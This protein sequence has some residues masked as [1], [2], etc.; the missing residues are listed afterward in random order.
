MRVTRRY[1]I[2]ALTPTM[3]VL[4]VVLVFPTLYVVQLAFQKK[5][6]TSLAPAQWVGLDNFTALLSD[7]RFWSALWHSALFSG[8]SL[9][10][11]IPIGCLLGA[12]MARKLPG[13]AF[14]RT[15]MILPMVVTP[16]VIG[17]LF[18]FILNSGGLADHLLQQ[19]GL[20]SIAFLAS[21]TLALPTVAFVDAWQWI[22]FVALVVL[23]GLESIPKE[24]LEA[25]R[26]DGAGPVRE[27]FHIVLPQ[28][29]PLLAVVVLVRL[30]DSF[31]EF[32]KIFIMTAGGPGTS[33]ETLPIYLWR[34]AFNYYEV[35]YA[36]AVGLVMLVLISLMST[37][38]VKRFRA[39]EGV[40]R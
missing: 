18:R 37:V 35:G 33:S 16:L 14:L 7:G 4:L 1:L 39:V 32:D 22:P 23:A 15:V 21:S 10:V 26:V 31:R 38:L 36:A 34:Y 13:T 5:R 17:A 28:L 30:M 12:L 9:A 20:P 29:R 11:S 3:L 6:L 8:I 27:F 2:Q 24:P 25:A 40:G 19:V